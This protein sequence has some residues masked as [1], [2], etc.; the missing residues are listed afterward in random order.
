MVCFNYS[1]S[2]FWF[3][4]YF[5]LSIDNFYGALYSYDNYFLDFLVLASSL[6]GSG[7]S[8]G[9]TQ[10]AKTSDYLKLILS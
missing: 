7:G 1:N 8:E 10:L 9:M 6:T 2:L 4:A 3:Y 5:V